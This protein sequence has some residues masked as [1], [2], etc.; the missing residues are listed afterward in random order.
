MKF[1][2]TPFVLLYNLYLRFGEKELP[3]FYSMLVIILNQYFYGAS[4]LDIINLK[5]ISLGNDYDLIY[6]FL[7]LSLNIFRFFYKKRYLK[8]IEIN[9]IPS[10]NKSFNFLIVLLIFGFITGIVLQFYTATLVRNSNI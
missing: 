5:V 2:S 8:L 3:H 4:I 6:G 9:P 10:N 1:F 7:I